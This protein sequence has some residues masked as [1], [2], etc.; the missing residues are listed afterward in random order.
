MCG[1]AMARKRISERD[2]QGELL[3]RWMVAGLISALFCEPREGLLARWL[4]FFYL[5]NYFF[6]IVIFYLMR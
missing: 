3:C 4:R 6:L 5:F 2:S 1:R